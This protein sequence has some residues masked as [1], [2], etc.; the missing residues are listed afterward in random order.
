MINL[1]G[2]SEYT[3]SRAWISKPC[4]DGSLASDFGCFMDDQRITGAGWQRFNKVRH[5]ISTQ[6]SY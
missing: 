1:P 5:A 3:S 2:T 6:E 4:S